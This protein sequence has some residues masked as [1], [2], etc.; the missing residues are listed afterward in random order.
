MRYEQ[1][2]VVSDG[3]SVDCHSAIVDSADRVF[4]IIQG[5]CFHS[6]ACR[7]CI[8]SRDTCCG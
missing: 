1:Q 8:I 5:Q 6:H 7:L 3:T 2:F 4:N